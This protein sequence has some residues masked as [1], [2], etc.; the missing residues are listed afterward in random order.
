MGNGADAASIFALHFAPRTIGSGSPVQGPE[1]YCRS[2]GSVIV[3]TVAAPPL[4][5]LPTVTRTW[6]F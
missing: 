3:K 4:R 5:V 2:Y 6:T 1:V